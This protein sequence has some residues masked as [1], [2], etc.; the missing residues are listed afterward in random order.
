MNDSDNLTAGKAPLWIAVTVAI[1]HVYV[2]FS[3]NSLV[4]RGL[5]ILAQG[6]WPWKDSQV[7]VRRRLDVVEAA[8]SP[9]PRS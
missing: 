9:R 5:R 2:G 8:R 3:I 4:C 7:S 1:P 6:G